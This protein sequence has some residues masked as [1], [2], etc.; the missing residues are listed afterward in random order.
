MFFLS[1][2]SLYSLY[3]YKINVQ[4]K[5]MATLLMYNFLLIAVFLLNFFHVYFCYE[6]A[7]VYRTHKWSYLTLSLMLMRNYR[8]RFTQMREHFQKFL[9]VS[10]TLLCL[11]EH[12]FWNMISKRIFNKKIEGLEKRNRHAHR[13][14][15]LVYII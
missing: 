9:Q 12:R 11:I 10:E 2:H 8:V 13:I 15:F 4:S 6:F 14:L 7:E 1:H 5:W 3:I